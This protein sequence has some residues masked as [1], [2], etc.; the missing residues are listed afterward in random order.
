MPDRPLV[1]LPPSQGK[2]EGGR[3]RFR[4]RTG[5]FAGLAAQRR[6][7]IEALGAALGDD[8]GLASTLFGAE[9]PLLD[10][11]IGS[12]E[13][14]VAGTAPVVPGA[15]RFT[16]VVWDHLAPSTV[17]DTCL[18]R[19]IVPS[20]LLGAVTGTDPTPDHR[21]TFTVSVP[22]LGR[23]DRWWR[24]EL[25]KAVIDLVGGRP[26]VEM[27]PT[28]HQRA[29]DLDEVAA[30]APL[31]RVRFVSRTGSRAVGHAAKAVKGIAAR[32]VLTEG[33]GA[34]RELAWE[35]WSAHSVADDRIEIVAP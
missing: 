33:L 17:D 25:S 30:S 27:L 24:P 32:T 14:L 5:S 10:R 35:G 20:A 26:V 3:G 34:L 1:L 2:A 13:R 16:G 7:V 22:G 12:I 15:A 11:A 31:V 9:G 4:P 19:L 28:E 18:E 6:E 8:P 23:L 29:L 21:L